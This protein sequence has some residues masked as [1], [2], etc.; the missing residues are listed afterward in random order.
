MDLTKLVGT[1]PIDLLNVVANYC[2]MVFFILPE[3]IWVKYDWFKLIRLNFGLVYSR[4]TCSNEE[5]MR[6][7]LDCCGRKK[8]IFSSGC[9]SCVLVNGVLMSCGNNNSGQLGVG[10]K[11]HRVKFEKVRLGK[12]IS[13]V[14]CLGM[15]TVVRLMDGKLM[16]CGDGMHGVL[17]HGGYRDRKK[18]Y[19]VEGIKSNIAEI[20]CKEFHIMVRFE[21]GRLMGCGNNSYGQLGL[22][23]RLLRYTFNE[24]NG[25]IDVEKVICSEKHTIIKLRDGRLMSCGFN[26]GGQLGLGDNY[27]RN[28]FNEIKGVGSNVVEVS[29]GGEFSV[30]RLRDGGLMSCGRNVHGELGVGDNRDR[31][32]FS[33]IDDIGGNI[34]EVICSSCYCIIRLADGT[35]MGCGGNFYG[36]LGLGDDLARNVFCEIKGI[37]KNIV[38]V[39]CCNSNLRIFI[40]LTDGTLMCSGFNDCGQLGLGDYL[41]R[42]RF[43]KITGIKNVREIMTGLDHTIIR[44]MDGTIMTCG[45]NSCGELGLG[46]TRS[47][48]VFEIVN[49]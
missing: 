32:V 19:K 14:K 22:G 43:C 39:I 30:V 29:C 25:P 33:K 42:S 41:N 17:G 46:D 49:L 2:P 15:Y 16:S 45:N 48:N 7:Y 47:R 20:I 10:D 40:R 28:T 6:V 9:R 35:L 34:V 44:L 26:R 27:Y 13:E 11:R 3:S 24:I 4:E 31:N 1:L 36:Q 38:E 5:I 12:Y 21:D 23:D 18:F 37:P 8:S